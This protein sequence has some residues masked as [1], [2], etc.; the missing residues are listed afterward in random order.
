[1]RPVQKNL[2]FINNCEI[3]QIS[4]I[5][6]SKLNELKKNLNILEDLT[7][8]L[9]NSM[10]NLKNLFDKINKDKEELKAQV[11][12]IFTKIRNELNDREDLLYLEIDELFDNLYF[13]EKLMREIEMLP[14][15]SQKNLEKGKLINTD[16]N[17]LCS[18]IN[19]C[20]DIEDNIKKIEEFK[21]LNEKCNQSNN[22][23]I[24]FYPKDKNLEF[25]Q[26]EIQNLRIESI[27][28]KKLNQEIILLYSNEKRIIEA[29]N[30]IKIKEIKSKINPNIPSKDI[31]L[32]DLYGNILNDEDYFDSNSLFLSFNYKINIS[33]KYHG[34]CKKTFNDI[35]INN[36][37]ECIRNKIKNELN[38]NKSDQ[39]IVH[40]GNEIKGVFDMI[41]IIEK[42]DIELD[43][44]IGPKDGLLIDIKKKSGEIYKYSFK[45]NTKIKDI[46]LYNLITLFPDIYNFYF[47]GKLLDKEKTLKDNNIENKSLLDFV[48]KEYIVIRR[49][50]TGQ[51]HDY[52]NLPVL[53]HKMGEPKLIPLEIDF[54][55]TVQSLKMKFS[56]KDLKLSISEQKLVYKDIELEDNKLLKEYN[57][58]SGEVID[59]IYKSNINFTIFIRMITGKK[60]S[61][62]VNWFDTFYDLKVKISKIEGLHPNDQRLIF[63]GRV[64]NDGDTLADYNISKDTT[65]ILAPR[66]RPKD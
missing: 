3:Y 42:K 60:L 24:E 56:E 47:K 8:F 23:R 9:N 10:N 31:M 27:N 38:I 30:R 34:I 58:N 36:S 44:Y 11:Q 45:S 41:K 39:R 54:S 5:K 20:I 37:L 16:K 25:I 4:E 48:Y 64:A 40:K 51:L 65:F 53:S 55:E 62:N 33:I 61:I 22:V 43:L 14:K 21:T 1:M 6:D 15:D 2:G 59:I 49:T 66:L 19:D 26:K 46:K 29:D 13:D 50:W 7:N 12:K 57:I 28:S 63:M 35:N 17:N 18:I 52:E 32:F